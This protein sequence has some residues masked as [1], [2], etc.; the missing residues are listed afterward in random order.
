VNR[1]ILPP[2]RNFAKHGKAL[3]Y[4]IT[5]AFSGESYMSNTSHT[6]NFSIIKDYTNLGP[7]TE[8]PAHLLRLKIPSYKL[9]DIFLK[10]VMY[11]FHDC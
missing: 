5:R 7:T 3:G 1:L 2:C 9:G 6:F 4:I 10:E 8:L 11:I